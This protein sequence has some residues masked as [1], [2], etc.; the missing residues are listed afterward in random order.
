MWICSFGKDCFLSDVSY[1]VKLLTIQITHTSL[2]SMIFSAFGVVYPCSLS[3]RRVFSG[4]KSHS[5]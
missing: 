4:M 5:C 1:G 2:S 3:N